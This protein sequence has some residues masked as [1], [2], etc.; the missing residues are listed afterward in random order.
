[1]LVTASVGKRKL[2]SAASGI[3]KYKKRISS[4]RSSWVSL[5]QHASSV[6]FW[7]LICIR[8]SGLR[9]PVHVS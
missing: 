1:M 3:I 2:R 7:I 4:Q 9:L 8:G 5:V 6:S